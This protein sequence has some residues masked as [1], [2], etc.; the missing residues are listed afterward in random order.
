MKLQL[1]SFVTCP[2]VQRAL[3]L[4]REKNAPHEV[5]YIELANKPDWFLKISPRGKVPVLVVDETPIFESQAICEYLDEV[6][7][8]PRMVPAD[9]LLRARERGWFRFAEDVFSPAYRRLYATDSESY[10]RAEKDLADVLARLDEEMNNRDYLS[11]DGTKFGL[12][13]VALAPAFTQLALMRSLGGFEIPRERILG[14]E[15]VKGS[16]RDDYREVMLAG[17][18]KKNAVMLAA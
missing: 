3:I 5:T 14:R 8:P 16:I 17:M 2:F 15:S 7:P 9:P 6:G 10:A 13:D 18:K 1:I 4:L 11:G 12:A